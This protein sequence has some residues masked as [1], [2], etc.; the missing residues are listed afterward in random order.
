MEMKS[1]GKS[2]VLEATLI[3]IIAPTMEVIVVGTTLQIP[4]APYAIV[5]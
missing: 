2:E 3:A 4:S 5:V 1:S